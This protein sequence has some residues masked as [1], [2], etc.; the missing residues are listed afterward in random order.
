MLDLENYDEDNHD[1]G[2]NELAELSFRNPE[3]YRR[4]VEQNIPEG[5]SVEQ[6]EQNN[7]E[8]MQNYL[9]SQRHG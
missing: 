5:L 3:K 8:Y 6:W 7:L 2:P 1:Y 9:N 4:I